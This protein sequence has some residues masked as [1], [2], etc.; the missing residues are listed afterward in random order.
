MSET[1]KTRRTTGRGVK[2]ALAVSLALRLVKE[3]ATPPVPSELCTRIAALLL[4]EPDPV[5]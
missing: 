4:P 2:I 3:A 1:G 5:A